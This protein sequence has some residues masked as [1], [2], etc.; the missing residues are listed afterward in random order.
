MNRR[1]FLYRKFLALASLGLLPFLSACGSGSPDSTDNDGDSPDTSTPAGS[2]ED[3][4][5][6]GAISSNHGHILNV[7]D[8]DVAN[9]TQKSYNIQGTGD[10]NHTVTLTADHF[11]TLQD[12]DSVTINS[13][14]GAHTH[15]VKV[16]CR[17]S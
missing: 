4:G 2:C 7:S 12:G 14:G 17:T 8:T 6:I 16:S 10:H 9:G 1:F 15:S 3:Y 13:T 5:T 11:T